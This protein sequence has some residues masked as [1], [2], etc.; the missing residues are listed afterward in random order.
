MEQTGAI[1]VVDGVVSHG[2]V[3][4][5]GGGWWCE[6]V[7]RSDSVDARKT[8]SEQQDRG[9]DEFHGDGVVVGVDQIYLGSTAGH[10]GVSS[11]LASGWG[12]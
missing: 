11:S 6:L 4:R 8:N 7:G 1:K 5:C 10:G 12:E 9:E 3:V 2:D